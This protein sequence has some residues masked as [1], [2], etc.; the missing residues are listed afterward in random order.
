MFLF[1]SGGRN[2]AKIRQEK[3]K[4]EICPPESGRFF[5]QKFGV[6]KLAIIHKNI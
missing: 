2:A 5:L 1:I 4:T 6:M 3:R